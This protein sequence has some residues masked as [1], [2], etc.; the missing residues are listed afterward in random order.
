LARFEGGAV[1][2]YPIKLK[3]T[4]GVAVIIEKRM[5]DL[6]CLEANRV[7]ADVLHVHPFA[8]KRLW[9]PHFETAL[10]FASIL[11]RRI[12]L[13]LNNFKTH[14]SGSPFRFDRKIN[15]AV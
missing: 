15:E 5:A 13:G 14:Q 9:T 3:L 4:R 1:V 11:A 10:I 12:R 7:L 2:A 8:E 6:H